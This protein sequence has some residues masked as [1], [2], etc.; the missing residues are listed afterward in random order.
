MLQ[1]LTYVFSNKLF[2]NWNGV[3]RFVSQE[4]WFDKEFVIWH[5]LNYC[6]VQIMSSWSL[7]IGIG[8][9]F[10]TNEL[11]DRTKNFKSNESR[12]ICR[13]LCKERNWRLP[14]LG[15][16]HRMVAEWVGRSAKNVWVQAYKNAWHVPWSSA[17]SLYTFPTAE[18]D[19]E[20]PMPSGRSHNGYVIYF[21]QIKDQNVLLLINQ[22]IQRL[23]N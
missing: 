3:V 9:I 7:S 11:V 1:V 13:T 6:L 2:W 12:F 19:H 18:G 5:F 20:C 4:V 8:T 14:V 16:P 15:R 23:I 21:P 10:T 22:L 17:N